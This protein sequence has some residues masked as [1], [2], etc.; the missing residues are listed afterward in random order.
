MRRPRDVV[1]GRLLPAAL[2]LSMAGC[3]AGS[4]AP[5]SVEEGAHPAGPDGDPGP[6]GAGPAEGAVEAG[7]AADD[8]TAPEQVGGGDP[9]AE[10][11]E[12]QSVLRFDVYLSEGSIDALE[13]DHDA[14]VPGFL[15]HSEHWLPD[16]GVRLKGQWGSF[17]E[18]DAKA[19]FKIALDEFSPGQRLLGLENL[20]LNN[21]VQDPS[22]AHET[23]AYHLYRAAGVP[24]PRTAHA[25]VYVNDELYGLYLLVETADDD[26]LERW[27]D[28][29]SGNLYEGEYGEDVVPNHVDDLELDEEGS[30]PDRADLWMLSDVLE[31]SPEETFLTDLEGVLDV[32]RF[33][34]M[35]AIDALIG[36]WDGYAYYPNNYRLYYEPASARFTVLPWGTDQTFD[37]SLNPFEMSGRI[38]VRCVEDPECSEAYRVRLWELAERFV[39]HD[40]GARRADLHAR[41]AP[42]I[43]RDPRREVDVDEVEEWNQALDAFVANRPAEVLDLLFPDGVP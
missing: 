16:V 43:E 30:P 13:E 33:L 8:D 17:R 14:Y 6:E 31:S 12:A 25:E 3:A 11:L 34:S 9:T 21:M 28:D 1:R 5:E 18:L 26:F 10:L 40:L 38:S 41:I 37:S 4:D 23:L 29:P 42:A 7:A 20:T 39:D 2:A 32:D 27:F 24:A 35:M 22:F 19:A 36:H 15:G